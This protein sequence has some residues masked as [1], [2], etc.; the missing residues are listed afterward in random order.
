MPGQNGRLLLTA[1]DR[2]RVVKQFLQHI[3]LSGVADLTTRSIGLTSFR[4]L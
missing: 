3:T 4:Y 1:L 2:Q